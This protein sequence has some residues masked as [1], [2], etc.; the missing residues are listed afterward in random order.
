MS[1]CR[2]GGRKAVE[3][4]IAADV[5]C[6]QRAV[7]I[8]ACKI[9][10]HH[11]WQSSA[12]LTDISASVSSYWSHPTSC[13][14]LQSPPKGV[15]LYKL[16]EHPSTDASCCVCREAAVSRLH[17]SRRC[18]PHFHFRL[19]WSES[20]PHDPGPRLL[21]PSAFPAYFIRVPPPA[22]SEFLGRWIAGFCHYC[23]FV[24]LP[25]MVD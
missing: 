12:T 10:S 8:K 24:S 3:L 25:A 2:Y 23:S 9:N 18:T 21:S 20:T 16:Q 7:K 17:L 4:P 19:W 15:P 22:I 5:P 14:Y 1:P 13:L 6:C 11:G